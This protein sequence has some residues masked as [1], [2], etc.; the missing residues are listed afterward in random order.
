MNHASGA[1]PKVRCKT[2]KIA[3][4]LDLDCIASESWFEAPDVSFTWF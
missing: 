1:E 4:G 3:K 2:G